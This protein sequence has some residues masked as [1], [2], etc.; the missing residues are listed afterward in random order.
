MK[1]IE[2]VYI[3]LPNWIGDVCMARPSL[4]AALGAGPGLVAC[5]KPWAQEL[6]RDIPGLDFVPLSGK[7]SEDCKR[8]RAHRKA[9]P[10]SGDQAGLLLPDS[11]TSAL[12]FRL[13]GLPCAGYRDDGRALLLR[14]GQSKP[15]APLH[16][17]QS[18][19]QLT[20][21]AFAR[22]GIT[23]AAQPAEQTML[24]P[25]PAQTRIA[26]GAIEPLRT[27]RPLILIAPTATGQ[28]KG[29]NK[30]WPHFGVL[31]QQLQSQGY[32]VLMCP[33]ANEVQQA[34]QNAPDALLIPP[35]ALGTF[36][37][38]IRECALVICNDSGVAHLTALTQTPQLTLI[39]VTDPQRTRP[40]TPHATILGQNGQW[41]SLASVLDCVDQLL[42][43]P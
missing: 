30:V 20:R 22:W 32:T 26:Q 5:A 29:K 7:W 13:A 21:D 1:N 28:H 16:A 25:D 36:I 40:W 35:M 6:L 19:Y 23:L 38:L 2:R 37:A 33:P 27:G 43:K 39:G 14:W 41:P 34:R 11:L 8:I 3:R 31:T 18:W 24:E 9:H 12:A 15:Q 4:L 42:R 10:V 17:V